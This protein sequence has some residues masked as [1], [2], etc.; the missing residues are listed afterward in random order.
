MLTTNIQIE[1]LKDIVKRSDIIMKAKPANATISHI[2]GPIRGNNNLVIYPA[3]H[4]SWHRLLAKENWDQTE[5]KFL[6]RV[7]DKFTVGRT[8]VIRGVDLSIPMEVVQEKLIELGLSPSDV[9][10]IE[11]GKEENHR[12]TLSVAVTLNSQKEY[13]KF[14]SLKEIVIKW[15]IM[16]L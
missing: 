12:Q 7:Q 2:K 6:P 5:H 9:S 16:K 11:T 10:R 1:I 3:D 8:V 15:K 14:L 13:E 4:A